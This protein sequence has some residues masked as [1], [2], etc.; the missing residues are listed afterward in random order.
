[1]ASSMIIDR[2]GD[3][4]VANLSEP[5]AKW[6]HE[7]ARD[8]SKVFTHYLPIKRA[9]V[10]EA[11]NIAGMIIMLGDVD[12][13]MPPGSPAYQIEKYVE[14]MREDYERINDFLERSDAQQFEFFKL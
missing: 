3:I 6:L 9:V 14:L 12:P 8:K 1:M 13:R 7:Q 2:D 10:E 5:L 4:S 11:R